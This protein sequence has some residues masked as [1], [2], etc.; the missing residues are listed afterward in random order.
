MDYYTHQTL[1]SYFE[2]TMHFNLLEKDVTNIK[3]KGSV[4]I[5]ST[6]DKSYLKTVK[7]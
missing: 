1:Q 6:K 5:V 3:R 4:V 2:A 7:R